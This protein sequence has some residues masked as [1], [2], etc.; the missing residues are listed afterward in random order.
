MDYDF[1]SNNVM[2]F[3]VYLQNFL[4]H[5]APQDK[6]LEEL[7]FLCSKI[8]YHEND[9]NRIRHNNKLL[10]DLVNNSTEIES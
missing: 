7:Q 1:K 9:I 6:I 8:V 3:F 5:D 10:N 4:K 2:E